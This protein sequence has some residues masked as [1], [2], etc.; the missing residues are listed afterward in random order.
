MRGRAWR[1]GIRC[2]GSLLPFN[3]SMDWE[4]KRIRVLKPSFIFA[5]NAVYGA[6]FADPTHPFSLIR[7][8]LKPLSL[9][10]ENEPSSG[11]REIEF[12]FFHRKAANT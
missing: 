9:V 10:R 2:N 7:A 4:A 8:V 12:E 6:V 5:K 11:I 1:I 3:G